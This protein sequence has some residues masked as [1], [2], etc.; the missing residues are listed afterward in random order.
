M[1]SDYLE[2]LRSKTCKNFKRNIILDHSE[3]HTILDNLLIVADLCS[4][5]QIF[6]E[7]KDRHTM[8]Y[9]SIWRLG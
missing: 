3:A 2:V 6:W 1:Q 7:K 8:A 4:R 9:G 5:M